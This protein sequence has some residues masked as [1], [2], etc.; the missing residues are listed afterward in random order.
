MSTARAVTHC[1]FFE[2]PA[3]DFGRAVKEWFPMAA[4]LLEGAATQGQIATDT[5]ERHERLVALGSVTAGLTHELNNPVTAIM[6]ATATMRER[7]AGMRAEIGKVARGALS[8]SQLES[9]AALAG[10]A[11]DSRR[12]AK[13]KGLSPLE[14]G[15]REE[16]MTDWLE[17]HGVVATWDIAPTLVAAGLDIEWAQKVAT[18]VPPQLLEASLTYPARV[19]ESDA[20]V[21][22]I[23]DAAQR[24]SGLLASAKQ[25]TQMDRAPLQSF[26]VHE[27]LDAT[28]TML[29]HK[30]GDDIKV[31][32][33][34]DRTLP[35]IMAFPGEL[36]Q[37]WTNLIDNAA[38]A[39]DGKGTL[40]I[41]T[42]RNGDEDRLVIEI[43]DTGPGVPENIR[44]R[45][46]EPFFTTKEIG[47]GTGLGL[48][49][50]WRIIVVRHHGDIHVVSSPGDTRFQVYV[51]MRQEP[52]VV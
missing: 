48:D 38:D 21:D 5:V 6:R 29:H 13:T 23:S 44:T 14:I 31:V 32:R 50:A 34:Y 37:V 51:P 3:A 25:Y 11:V 41:R 19:L 36:N 39:M 1:K 24:I 16:E 22:E 10:A 46:F 26:D 4:H 42:H 35:H 30:L 18:L 27:G 15:D 47:H 2:L 17:D 12:E 9:L 8:A 28:L 20:M 52:A 40:T 49:I 7:I 33:D 43:C 45:I